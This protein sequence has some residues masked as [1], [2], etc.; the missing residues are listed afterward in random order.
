MSVCIVQQ[1]GSSVRNNNRL[2]LVRIDE[3][4]KA[5]AWVEGTKADDGERDGCGV[6]AGQWRAGRET[7]ALP[8][9]TDETSKRNTE[10]N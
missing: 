3:E 4:E 1:G 10:L 2:R 9:E 5:F 6:E 8:V 7:A